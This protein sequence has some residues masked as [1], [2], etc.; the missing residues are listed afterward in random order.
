MNGVQ[1]GSWECV[2]DLGANVTQ[3][4]EV[5]PEHEQ[6]VHIAQVGLHAKLLLDGLIHI[7]EADVC[8]ELAGQVAD[9]DFGAAPE[10]RQPTTMI[11]LTS[12]AVSGHGIFWSLRRPVA[13]SLMTSP[14]SSMFSIFTKCPPTPAITCLP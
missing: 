2:L 3:P 10:R 11:D 14:S 7:V 13:G 4:V 5:V 1:V 6:I 9:G 8:E 12:L